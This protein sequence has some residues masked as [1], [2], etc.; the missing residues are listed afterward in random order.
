MLLAEIVAANGASI[1]LGALLFGKVFVK[2]AEKP[3]ASLKLGIMVIFTLAFASL[4][5]N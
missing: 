2:C 1:A 4:K 3:K 5:N